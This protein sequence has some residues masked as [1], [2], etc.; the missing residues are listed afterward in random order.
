MAEV[1]LEHVEHSHALMRVSIAAERGTTTVDNTVTH[2]TDYI[3][4]ACT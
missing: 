4:A 3:E 1:S 2:K